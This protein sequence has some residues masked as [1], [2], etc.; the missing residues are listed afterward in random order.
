MSHNPPPVIPPLAAGQPHSTKHGS[1]KA[2]LIA[3]A[4][5]DHTLFQDYN[6]IQPLLCIGGGNMRYSQCGINQTFPAQ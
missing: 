4:S 2:E 6:S 5:H 3:C 1:I